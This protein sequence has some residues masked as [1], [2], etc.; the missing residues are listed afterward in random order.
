MERAL[1][2]VRGTEKRKGALVER[3]NCHLLERDGFVR[4]RGCVWVNKALNGIS[5]CLSSSVFR[6][7]T[8]R[9]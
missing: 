5:V 9:L 8:T 6:L 7:G 2:R 1:E 3:G 4:L